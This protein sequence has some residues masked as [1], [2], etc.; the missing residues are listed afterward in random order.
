MKD[1]EN[2]EA[3]ACVDHM[4]TLVKIPLKPSVSAF[5]GYLKRKSILMIFDRHANLKC[6]RGIETSGQRDIMLVR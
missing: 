5:V 2:I 4:H 1:V 6:K 3:H